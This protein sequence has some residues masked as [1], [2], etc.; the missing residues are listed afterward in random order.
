MKI[1]VLTQFFLPEMGAPQTRLYELCQGLQQLG[2]QV[3][4]VTAMPNYPNGKIADGY[5]TKFSCTEQADFVIHRYWLYA[6]NSQRTLP[7]IVSMLSFSFTALFSLFKV[8]KFR[9][10]Y[11]LVESPPLTLG[12]TGWLLSKFT[13]SRLIL[14]ISDLWP[15]SAKELGAINDGFAYRCLERLEDFLYQNSRICTGQSQEIVE[16][17]AARKKEKVWLLRN[18]VDTARFEAKANFKRT[19][20]IIYAGLLGVAQGIFA[21][22]HDI[23][24]SALGLELHIY[25]SGNEK[26]KI[27]NFLNQNHDKGIFYKGIVTRQQIPGTL[28]LY[29]A[30][31]VSLAKNIYGAVPSKIYEAMA[32]GLPIL[33]SGEGEGAKI[34]ETEMVGWVNNP[35]DLQSFKNNLAKLHSLSNESLIEMKRRGAKVAKEKFDRTKQIQNLHQLLIADFTL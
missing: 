30:A 24:F 23:N 32:A 2:W 3:E 18:G 14:N 1:V 21:L 6:S 12:F 17:I 26:E 22:C 20:K 19:N 35:K 4:V 25:G 34:V 33:F 9:P 16:Y 11:L 8:K 5:R 29:D 13:S 28:L 27:V 31:L 15:L 10:H 7:R